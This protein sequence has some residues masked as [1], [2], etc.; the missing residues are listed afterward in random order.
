MKIYEIKCRFCGIK[1]GELKVPDNYLANPLLEIADSRCDAHEI[2]H[3]NYKEMENEYKQ[4]I[5]KPN[6]EFLK[7]MQKSEFKRS[8]FDTELEKE[9]LEIK[10]KEV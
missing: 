7:I 10:K 5:N 3:G 2:E 9:I 6:A 8:K 1:N 4:K